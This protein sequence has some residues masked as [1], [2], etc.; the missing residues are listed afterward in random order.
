MNIFFFVMLVFN[1]IYQTEPKSIGLNEFQFGFH[2]ELKKKIN[3][4]LGDSSLLSKTI[5]LKPDLL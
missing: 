4:V 5:S 2:F 3:L 1:N